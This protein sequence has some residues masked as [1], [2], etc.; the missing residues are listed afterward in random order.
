VAAAEAL[1]GM[2]GAEAA[3]AALAQCRGAVRWGN[4]WENVEKIA[5][6][7]RKMRKKHRIST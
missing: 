7:P 1:R 2:E 5:V 4:A 3:S 6:S